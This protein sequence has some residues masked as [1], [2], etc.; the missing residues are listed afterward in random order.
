MGVFGTRM[1]NPEHTKFGFVTQLLDRVLNFQ[2]ATHGESSGLS[3]Y[4]FGSPP[5]LG[6]N[7][8]DFE[9]VE[10][11]VLCFILTVFAST[12]QE[13]PGFHFSIVSILNQPKIKK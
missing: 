11:V 4:L 3:S 7:P 8:T 13:L 1:R 6:W 12:R 10:P 5:T 2:Q 9:T